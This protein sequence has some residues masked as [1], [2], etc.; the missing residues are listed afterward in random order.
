[1]TFYPLIAIEHTGQLEL[2]HHIQIDKYLV[3]MPVNGFFHHPHL[4]DNMA[5]C[6]ESGQ[7]RLGQQEFQDQNRRTVTH[8][9]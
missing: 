8:R 3:G 5:N 6:V 9:L 7:L 2:A 1:M 4:T